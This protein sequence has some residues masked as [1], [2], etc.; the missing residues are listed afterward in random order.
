MH[1]RC[2]TVAPLWHHR[3]TTVEFSTAA[4]SPPWR[5]H[6]RGKIHRGIFL[7]RG[8]ATVATRWPWKKP[9]LHHRGTAVDFYARMSGAA[10]CA[11]GLVGGTGRGRGNARPK[12]ARGIR[13][14][15]GV[16]RTPKGLPGDPPEGQGPTRPA[17]ARPAARLWAVA[18]RGPNPARP[19]R[20]F[21]SLGAWKSRKVE[22]KKILKMKILKIQNHVGQ[23]VDKVWIGRIF[24]F[25]PHNRKALVSVPALRLL[26][27]AYF[28]GGKI[29]DG[30][31]T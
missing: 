4:V 26:R 16:P 19:G 18:A 2:T 30:T 15:S 27:H 20:D 1:H 23:N 25:R 11:T 8:G 21:G 3:G 28:L 6:G 29:H 12:H 22:S 10:N 7:G 14:A 31:W 24:S 9:P 5:L 17:G 13:H